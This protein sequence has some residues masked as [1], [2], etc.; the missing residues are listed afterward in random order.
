MAEMEDRWL[1][2][3]GRCTVFLDTE[4][5]VRD[6]QEVFDDEGWNEGQRSLLPG[7]GRP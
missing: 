2:V 5:G 4:L 3:V 7:G 6:P 1:S